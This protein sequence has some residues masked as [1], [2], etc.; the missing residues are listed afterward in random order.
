MLQITVLEQVRT[1]TRIRTQWVSPSQRLRLYPC[2]LG[3]GL[4]LHLGGL[5]LWS[6]GLGLGLHPGGL[7]LTVSPGESSENVQ[8]KLK[9]LCATMAKIRERINEITKLVPLCSIQHC[10]RPV[11]ASLYDTRYILIPTLIPELK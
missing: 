9:L 8:G 10:N 3:L 6:D 11:P 4:A 1:L 2:G 7:G 5:G